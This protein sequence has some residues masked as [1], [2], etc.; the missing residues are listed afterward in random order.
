M[1]AVSWIG[2]IIGVIIASLYCMFEL[3]PRKKV[4]DLKNKTVWITGKVLSL[5][6]FG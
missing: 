1:W 4:L 6:P 3:K 5:L 2:I